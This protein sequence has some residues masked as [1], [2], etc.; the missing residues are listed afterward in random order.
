MV[1]NNV[2]PNNRVRSTAGHSVI[3]RFGDVARDM[4]LIQRGSFA[5][6]NQD[7]E[8]VR[9]MVAGEFFGEMVPYL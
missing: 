4:F 7:S 9:I 2:S 6:I 8:C 5:V 1:N 3:I